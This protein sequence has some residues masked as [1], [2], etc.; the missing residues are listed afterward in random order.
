MRC[1]SYNQQRAS[2]HTGKATAATGVDAP[3]YGAADPEYLGATSTSSAASRP[4]ITT[5]PL[6]DWSVRY[7]LVLR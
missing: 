3:V 4:I 2:S 5:Q 1:C 6:W 7:I